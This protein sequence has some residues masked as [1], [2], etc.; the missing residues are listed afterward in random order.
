MFQST[1]QNV[2]TSI[3]K[4]PFCGVSPSGPSD[5]RGVWLQMQGLGPP[6][7]FPQVSASFLGNSKKENAEF[8]GF[9]MLNQW[10][11]DAIAWKEMELFHGFCYM[12]VTSES[13]QSYQSYPTP[14]PILS[15]FF[16]ETPKRGTG[17]CPVV[18]LFGPAACADQ[19]II[20]QLHTVFAAKTLLATK[21]KG[22]DDGV[23]AL[24]F[25]AAWKTLELRMTQW[26]HII[27]YISCNNIYIN[28]YIYIYMYISG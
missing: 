15:P 5:P 19:P 11:F 28:V 7:R 22:L 27:S 23:T 3:G 16:L 17:F 20:E 10:L 8:G 24:F 12:I 4:P 1:K 14:F 25:K 13:Y 6:R 21:Q 9:W 26:W 18:F 2:R